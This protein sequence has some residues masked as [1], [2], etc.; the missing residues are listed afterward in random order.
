MPKKYTGIC[1][2]CIH[3]QQI[4]GSQMIVGFKSTAENVGECRRYPPMFIQGSGHAFP[5]T[6]FNDWCSIG[7]TEPKAEYGN[8]EPS[9][10]FWKIWKKIWKIWKKNK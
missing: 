5:V 10:P 6:G 7:E 4:H 3:W 8:I 2:E 9:I 1:A